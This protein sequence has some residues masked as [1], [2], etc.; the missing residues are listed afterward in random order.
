MAGF[1]FHVSEGKPVDSEPEDRGPRPD[2]L[3]PVSGAPD[4][5]AVVRA[6]RTLL[7]LGDL[8]PARRT[9][10]GRVFPMWRAFAG[11]ARSHTRYQK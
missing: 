1:S 11:H 6:P 3:L 5:G 9:F 4:D 10:C 8:V 7:F 2:A